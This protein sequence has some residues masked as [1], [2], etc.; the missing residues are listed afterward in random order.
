V[1]VL[2]IKEEGSACVITGMAVV[3]KHDS[4]HWLSARGASTGL[5]MSSSRG[6]RLTTIGTAHVHLHDG[7][8]HTL[9]NVHA[10][11][12]CDHNK[13]EHRIARA[14]FEHQRCILLLRT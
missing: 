14:H 10:T 2:H 6:I 11:D 1:R 3:L 8:C 13:S 12:E 4:V 7:G 9:G 5:I